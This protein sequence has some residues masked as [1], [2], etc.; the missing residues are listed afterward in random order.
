MGWR[1]GVKRGVRSVACSP[2]VFRAAAADS[3]DYPTREMW[4]LSKARGARGVAPAR[5]RRTRS[6]A[7]APCSL[8]CMPTCTLRLPC[9]PACLQADTLI[10]FTG[11]AV[12]LLLGFRN[13]QAYAVGGPRVRC[14]AVRQPPHCVHA[15]R[16]RSHP[17]RVPHAA[18][19]P[20]QPRFSGHGVP[21]EQRSL[22]TSA[23][24]A[25]RQARR[26]QGAAVVAGAL[27]RCWRC[28]E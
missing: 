7:A 18:L 20:R 22:V 16:T 10:S 5:G 3:N 19:G 27:G 8:Q 9:L 13:S 28:L 23:G 17:P 6:A 21:P 2:S 15:C 14:T 4:Q 11:I 1:R 25:S 26:V 24:A 12:F